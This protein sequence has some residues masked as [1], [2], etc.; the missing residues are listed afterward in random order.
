MIAETQVLIL[1]ATGLVFAIVS[2]GILGRTHD[3]KKEAVTPGSHGHFGFNQHPHDDKS[4]YEP[5]SKEEIPTHAADKVIDAIGHHYEPPKEQ[6]D[7][8]VD[9]YVETHNDEPIDIPKIREATT[10]YLIKEYYRLH[11]TSL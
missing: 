10:K 4:S 11:D 6:V 1:A 5:P 9:A 3:D 8:L 7:A 2:M